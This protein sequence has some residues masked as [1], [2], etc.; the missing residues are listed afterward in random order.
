MD[1]YLNFCIF[2]RSNT[3]QRSQALLLCPVQQHLH[4]EKTELQ[5]HIWL[6]SFSKR[7][8]IS[9]RVAD[10]DPHY[11]WKLDPDHPDPHYSEKKLDPD[12]HA[13]YSEKLDPDP[14]PH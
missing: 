13:H 6:S 4:R 8:R 11:F 5:T 9:I 2:Y 1:L 14:H 12:P 7:I 10:L 3:A